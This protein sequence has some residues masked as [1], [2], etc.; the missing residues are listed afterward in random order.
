[1]AEANS[2]Q[3]SSYPN[4]QSMSYYEPA[5]E[6]D[7][8]NRKISLFGVVRSFV[9]QLRPGQDLT[10]VSVPAVMLY[11]YSILEVF[12]CRELT[13]ID[14][15]LGINNEE[16]PLQRMLIVI[17][18]LL[19]TIQQETFY[20]KPYNP[21]IGETHEC[22]IDSP[23]YGRSNF[24][25]EQVSHHPPISAVYITNTQQGITFLANLS[26][27]VKF[28][29]NYLAV[30]TEGACNITVDKF[31]EEYEIPKRTPDMMVKNVVFGTKRIFWAG[32]IT[33]G[34]SKTGYSANLSFKESGT[35]NV[36]RG[37]IIFL[38]PH[39]NIEHELFSLEGKC[40]GQIFITPCPAY[41]SLFS[42][43]WDPS[44]KKLL[45]DLSSKIIFYFIKLTYFL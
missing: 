25:A 44:E 35:D 18:W 3:N 28:G 29:G 12:G 8:K 32:D 45:A 1:M 30:V 24:V 31:N 15:I 21:V 5:M 20:K 40:G 39:S 36:V 37:N 17:K 16:D 14:Y 33:V 4:L 7:W 38:D 6:G 13:S 23:E 11:P 27:G 41:F 19:S 43:S 34:C 2:T 9:S 10:R 26:F 22:W 42:T